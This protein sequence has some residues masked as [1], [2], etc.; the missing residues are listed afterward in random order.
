MSVKV[1]SVGGNKKT[2]KVKAMPQLVLVGYKKPFTGVSYGAERAKQEEIF[3]ATR[4]K[5][6]LLMGASCDYVDIR[7]NIITEWLPSSA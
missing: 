2:C 1:D 5:R 6:W 7:K 4:A 3:I